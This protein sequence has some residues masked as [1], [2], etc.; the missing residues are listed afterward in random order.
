MS[1]RGTAALMLASAVLVTAITGAAFWGFRIQRPY[2]PSLGGFWL[3]ISGALT[4]LGL[5]AMSMWFNRRFVFRRFPGLAM[6]NVG[7][8]SISF[9]FVGMWMVPWVNLTLDPG[10]SR[11]IQAVVRECVYSTQR[12]RVGQSAERFR[13]WRVASADAPVDFIG[14]SALPPTQD[15][16]GVGTVITM[17]LHPGRLGVPW[18]DAVV[19]SDDPPPSP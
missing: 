18:V 4:G 6:W 5:A 19:S 16:P 10:P 15:C 3:D 1:R 9:V 17:N 11:R 2:W 12:F 14:Q 13:G 8:S 7:L